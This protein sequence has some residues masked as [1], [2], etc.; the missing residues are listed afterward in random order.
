MRLV[1]VESPCA[2]DVELNVAYARAAVLD[3]LERGEAPFA[4]HLLY[5]QQGILDDGRP[6]DR[7]RGISAGLA[8]GQVAHAT[9]VYTDLG[10]TRG[11]LEGI[12]MAEQQGRRVERRTLPAWIAEHVTMNARRA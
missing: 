7:H 10:I 12:H 3:C 9:V 6:Y 4:S 5:T 2:G 8:W 11:M 1:I